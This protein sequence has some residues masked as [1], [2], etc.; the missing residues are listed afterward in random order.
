MVDPLSQNLKLPCGATL[1]NRLAKAPL[2]EGLADPANRATEKLVRLYRRW[3][4]GGAGLLVSGNVQVDRR[5]LERAGNVAI[6]DNGG[7]DEVRAYAAAGRSAGNHFWMQINHPGRQAAVSRDGTLMAPSAV[8]LKMTGVDTIEPRAMSEP[9]ILDVIRR[10]AKVAAVARDC[11]FT[12]VQVHAAHGYLL[13]QFLSGLTNIRTDMW[14]GSLANRARLLLETVR[15]VRHAVGADFPVGVKLNSADFQKGGFSNEDC[16]QVVQ[17][18]A[19]EKIDLLEISGGTYEQY[20][21]LGAGSDDAPPAAAKASTVAREGYF[22]DYAGRMRAVTKIPLM[23]TGGMRSR[24]AMEDALTRG[25]MDVIG[26]GRP[27]CV[28]TDLCRQL[29][30]GEAHSARRYEHEF[31]FD[32]NVLGPDMDPDIA[33]AVEVWG[34]VGWFFVQLWRLG[35]GLEPDRAMSLFDAYTLYQATERGMADGLA[36]L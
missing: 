3:S 34:H 21:M 20:A 36:P 33:K 25:G 28:D 19:Q 15:A 35:D 6:D 27:M 29:L 24:A 17:W 30:S 18:L 10:F 8:R 14:G 11:G 32:L 1:E 4:E 7:L 26:I 31:T 22:L 16:L 12:G 23:I 13:S 2:T 9:E 5:Y